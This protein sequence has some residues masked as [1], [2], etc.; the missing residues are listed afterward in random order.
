M[1]ILGESATQPVLVSSR[2]API[3]GEERWMTTLKTA[4][5]AD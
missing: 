2:N 5:V 1:S 3:S 4:G